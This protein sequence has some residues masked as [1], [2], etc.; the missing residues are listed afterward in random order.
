[1]TLH[2]KVSSILALS[3]INPDLRHLLLAQYLGQL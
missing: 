1:V 3:I 2:F